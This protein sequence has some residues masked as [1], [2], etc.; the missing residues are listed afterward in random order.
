[1]TTAFQYVF[2]KATS[3]S[4]NRRAV[5]AQTT[6]RDQTVRTVSRGGQV[7]RFDVQLPDGI[8]WT[9]LRPY[10]ESID[11]ADRYTVG[12]VQINNAGYND[13]LTP[14]QGNSV[15]YS[16]FSGS[17]TQGGTT[18]TLTVSPTTSSGYKFKKGDL[19]QLNYAG[20]GHVYSV[21]NDVVFNSNAVTVNRPILDASSTSVLKV[22]PD[23]TW[24][25]V[26]TDIPD[27]K[28]F[29]RDQISWSG[30]FKF[31]EYML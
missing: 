14:Y 22:G 8:S 16:G 18:I 31:M 28:I 15:N 12:Q 23:V 1:M 4:I 26:C 24:S 9:T 3:I 20:S 21:A 7:W 17:W 30:S 29:A 19:I 2:D 5:V 6:T 27:W 10:I 13:W 25:V 11:Y